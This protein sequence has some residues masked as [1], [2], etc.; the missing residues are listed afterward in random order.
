MHGGPL[1]P[2]PAST[3]W[4]GGRSTAGIIPGAP[5]ATATAITNHPRCASQR[6]RPKSQLPDDAQ[7]DPQVVVLASIDLRS[8]HGRLVSARV[9][10]SVRKGGLGSCNRAASQ[11]AG[12]AYRIVLAEE[13]A[14]KRGRKRAQKASHGRSVL[15]ACF[16]FCP[17]TAYIVITHAVPFRINRQL[18]KYLYRIICYSVGAGTKLKKGG[19]GRRGYGMAT[20]MWSRVRRIHVSIWT[21]ALERRGSGGGRVAAR[22]VA[23][24]PA[25]RVREADRY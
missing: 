12:R 15:S 24:H 18:Q 11:A 16:R 17:G 4:A 8:Q 21:G 9:S 25:K 13:Q 23:P 7:S 19:R 5:R 3:Q 14:T 2:P 22:T 20:A 1:A 6:P 10:A